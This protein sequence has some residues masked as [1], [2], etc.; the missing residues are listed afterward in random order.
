VKV[1]ILA[2]GAG[3]RL[4]EETSVRPKPL[5]EIGG[6]P[7]L[8]HIMKLFS[9]YG[10]NDFAVALGYRGDDIKRYMLDLYE[11]EGS[12][13]IDY[14]ARDVDRNGHENH[15][16]DGVKNWRVDLV[17]T[18]VATQTGG[19]V[20]RLEPYLGASTFML[21]YGDGLADIDLPALLDFHR[22]HGRLATVTAVRPIARFGTLDM[23]GDHV[24]SFREKRAQDEGWINGGFFVLEPEVLEYVAGDETIWEREPLERLAQDRQLVAFRHTSFWQCMDTLREKQMLQELWDRGDAPWRVWG[25]SCE[26][27]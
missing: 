23:E 22:E 27:F 9:H 21:T 17:D 24:T 5:V 19:R 2:G 6:R 13:R 15:D 20:R 7:I 12:L 16:A 14:S 25:R 26:S 1:A 11:I 8:W 3:T 4:A 10:F 18:G